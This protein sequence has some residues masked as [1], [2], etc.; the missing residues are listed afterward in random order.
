MLTTLDFTKISIV[1]CDALGNGIGV[2]LMQEERL[3]AFESWPIKGNDLHKHIY[4][5]EMLTLVGALK[6]WCPYL[7][8]RHFKVKTYHYSLKY[9]LEHRLSSNKQQKWVTKML[10]YDFEIIYKKWKQNMVEDALSRKYEDV[11]TLLCALSI[12]QPDWIVEA[13]GEW[14]NH[15]STWTLIQKLQKDPS[16][17]DTFVW[18]NDSLWS[19]DRL[20]ICNNSQLKQISF[21]NYTPLL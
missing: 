2:V 1:E 15:L 4:E 10:G 16:V 7:I 19:K 18:K 9:F 12:I 11:V 13:K 21:W 8:G 17:L 20:Y 6:Q 5:K 14:K 3:L